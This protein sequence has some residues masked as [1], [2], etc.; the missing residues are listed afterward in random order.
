MSPNNVGISFD[1]TPVQK[2]AFAAHSQ[3]RPSLDYVGVSYE[4][5]NSVG[6]SYDHIPIRMERQN[7]QIIPSVIVY[8]KF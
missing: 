1:P 8:L 7:Y 4:R 6:V 3:I 5:P 2:G